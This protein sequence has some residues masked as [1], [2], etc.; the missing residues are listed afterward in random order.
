MSGEG[1][2]AT[3]QS[4]LRS[5][6]SLA[7]YRIQGEACFGSFGSCIRKCPTTKSLKSDVIDFRVRL[8]AT[9]LKYLQLQL[10]S[11]S[12]SIPNAPLILQIKVIQASSQLYKSEVFGEPV[13][14]AMT[15][16]DG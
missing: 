16:I 14:P 1:S 12:T 9:T 3:E 7:G 13:P 4:V 11:Y 8:E 5:S 15:D 6:T 10:K 2:I